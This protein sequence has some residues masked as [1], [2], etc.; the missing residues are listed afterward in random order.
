MDWKS[1][2]TTPTW[3]YSQELW[4]LVFISITKWRLWLWG[5]LFLI[6]ATK[7]SDDPNVKLWRCRT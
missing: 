2:L 5:E 4:F 1:I 7:I 3:I 6:I